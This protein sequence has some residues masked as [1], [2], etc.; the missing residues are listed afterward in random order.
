MIEFNEVGGGDDG[1]D[2]IKHG[3]SG[4]KVMVFKNLVV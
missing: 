3:R 2:F 1:D 4:K